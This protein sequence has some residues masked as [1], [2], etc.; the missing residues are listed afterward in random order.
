MKLFQKNAFTLVELLITISII[1]ILWT[2]AFLA[3][4]DY[5]IDARDSWRKADIKS[6]ETLVVAY[7]AKHG[8]VPEPD[9]KDGIGYFWTGVTQQISN[10]IGDVPT[11]PTTNNF[12]YYAISADKKNFSLSTKLETTQEIYA[13]TSMKPESC[14]HI[15]IMGIGR[16]NGTYTLFTDGKTASSVTCDLESIILP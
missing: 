4:S 7:K 9:I 10:D 13:I 15:K 14:Q 5:P 16:E 2:I 6:L 12:Y 1:A 11:D 3:F 8:K